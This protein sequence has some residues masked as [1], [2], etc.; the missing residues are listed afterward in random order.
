MYNELFRLILHPS[1]THT[2]PSTPSVSFHSVP[3]SSTTER[4]CQ[5]THHQQQRGENDQGRRR[6]TT[7]KRRRGRGRIGRRRRERIEDIVRQLEQRRWRWRN[8]FIQF[9]LLQWHIRGHHRQLERLRPVA[10]VRRQATTRTQ[11]TPPPLALKTWR[12]AHHTRTYL[13]TQSD[14]TTSTKAATILR[15]GFARSAELATRN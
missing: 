15:C 12:S 2:E 3:L 4:C 8:V 11:Q 7:T 10:V 5:R 13:K 14:V 6:R 9:L 1:R